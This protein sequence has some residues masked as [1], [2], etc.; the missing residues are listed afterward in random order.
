VTCPS[1]KRSWKKRGG[2]HREAKRLTRM[3]R[4]SANKARIAGL[5]SKEYR[6]EDCGFWHVAKRNERVTP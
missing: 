1:G 2:A 5:E 3:N 4:A 6:C